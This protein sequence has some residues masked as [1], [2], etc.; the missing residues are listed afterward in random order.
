[1]NLSIDD[2][3]LLGKFGAR[4]SGIFKTGEPIDSKLDTLR[5]QLKQEK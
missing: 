1:M 3:V 2:L 5:E 4:A